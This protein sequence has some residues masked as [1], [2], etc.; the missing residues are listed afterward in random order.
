MNEIINFGDG[1]TVKVT[2]LKGEAG[3][4]IQSVDKTSTSGLVDTYTI[5]LT[6]GTTTTF[7]V[8][9]GSSIQSIEKTNTQGL[10]DTY[11]VTL[12]N[13]NT[14]TFTVTNGEYD[15][16]SSQGRNLITYPYARPNVY[17]HNGVTY[18]VNN[19]GSIT[20]NGTATADSQF[21]IS[22]R[23]LTSGVFI[24][25]NKTY[26]LS[27]AP[28]GSSANTYQMA[29]SYS[30]IGGQNYS[31]H[32]YGNGVSFTVRDDYKGT[33]V[34]LM[35]FIN[36]GQTVNNLTFR[37]MLEVGTIAHA[38]EPTTQSALSLRT[39]IADVEDG[40][41]ASKTYNA[42][43]YIL[44]NGQLHR[45]T[46]TI[47]GGTAITEGVNIESVTVGGEISEINSNLSHIGMVIHSTTLD[48]EAK[49]I[50]IYGGV[51]WARIE[52]RMLIGAGSGY[53]IN[54]T[55]GSADATLV[56]HS[57]SIPQLSGTAASAG[58]H[59]HANNIYWAAGPTGGGFTWGSDFSQAPNSYSDYAGAHTHSVTTNASTTGN[60]G[61]SGAGKNLPPYKAVYIWERTE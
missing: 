23:D 14:S 61:Q 26:I 28:S 10:V 41:V 29:I 44:R 20:A 51:H 43:D 11:T 58:N 32:D 19:D 54:S 42:G 59:N 5:T 17:A 57:H 55:G 33:S 31:Y 27:G 45:V 60:Q 16:P 52:D 12:T 35:V 46:Q 21:N 25:R 50:A 48:T 34:L 1:K 53:A 7:Q 49:V 37:P 18:T 22:I 15:V 3:N 47:A 39:S 9:N 30:T 56:S 40:S 36:S 6:D 4:N 24:E 2:L 8:T 38:Y 13:G